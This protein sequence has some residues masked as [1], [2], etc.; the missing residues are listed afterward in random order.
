[1]RRIGRFVG[2]LS[3]CFFPAAPVFWLIG[4]FVGGGQILFAIWLLMLAWFAQ[5]S[6]RMA[7]RREADEAVGTQTMNLAAEEPWS[8]A[9][10]KANFWKCFT[11]ELI[12]VSVATYVFDLSMFWLWF[13]VAVPLVLRKRTIAIMMN[14]Q[15]GRHLR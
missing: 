4:H 15:A 9:K 13:F 10:A 5:I 2:G 7:R 11:I 12:V 1:M 3:F 8:A 14:P 6:W